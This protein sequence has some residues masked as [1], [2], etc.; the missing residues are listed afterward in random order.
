MDERVL[1]DARDPSLP[2]GGLVLELELGCPLRRLGV[3]SV[4]RM[5]EYTRGSNPD[6]E[7]KS[8]ASLGFFFRQF[9]FTE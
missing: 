7:R 4:L 9:R 2:L 3:R 5:N 8:P 1:V 6:T